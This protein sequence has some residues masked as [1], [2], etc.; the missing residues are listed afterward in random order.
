MQHRILSAIIAATLSV[1]A[2]GQ[3]TCT[4]K[5][6]IADTQLGDGTKVKKV[7][8]TR[9]NELGQTLEVATAKVKKG[10]YTF[11]YTLAE[12][13]P[14]LQYHITG[15]GEAG[16]IALFV[17][18]GEVNV[19]T[20]LATRPEQSTLSGTPT[21]ELY[22]E[23]RAIYSDGASEV[24]AQLAALEEANGAAWLETAEGKRE[25]KRIEAK[26]AIKTRTQVLRFF[27]DHNDSPMTPLE[28]ERTLL[29]VLSDAYAEQITKAM[30][31]T[32]HAHPYYISLRNSMLSSALKVGNEAPSVTLPL[33]SGETKQLSDYRGKY[34]ILNFWNSACEKSAAMLAEMKNVYE[35]VKANADQFII[36]SIALDNDL[37]TWREAVS[38]NDIDREDWLHACEGVGETSL[39]A[40]LFKVEAAPKVLLIEP[41]GRAV[42]LDMELDE[43]VMRLEQILMGD[44]YYLDQKE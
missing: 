26:E 14:T 12:N 28:V 43:I 10:N 22:A 41:E 36:L 37:A 34:V 25:V 40:K 1:A 8:L 20:A 39:A 19:S 38:N 35:V 13:E 42:S 31:T 23:Y 9:T 27:I 18:P 29:P 4:I 5:G 44:L 7:A 3:E 32:L 17:E 2:I 15:F 6:H 11:T 33:L 21:N 16:S 30:S 24:A